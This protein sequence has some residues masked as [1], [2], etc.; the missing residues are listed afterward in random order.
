MYLKSINKT[1]FNSTV[2]IFGGSFDPI[3]QGHVNIANLVTNELNLDELFFM[4]CKNHP[5]KKA[6]KANEDHRLA[7]LELAL[8]DYPHL[9]IDKRE[10]KRSGDSFTFD[11]L[12]SLRLEYSDDS[13]IILLIGS[14]VFSSL[15]SWFR[16]KDI[17]SLTNIVVI[18]RFGYNDLAQIKDEY[19][20]SLLNSAV[21]KIIFPY[22]QIQ[23]L[24]LPH[25]DVSSSDLRLRFKNNN[26]NLSDKYICPIVLDYIVKRKLYA[27]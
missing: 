14:D 7:M 23:I 19:L 9:K 24:S 5:F 11:S 10:L 22:G 12:K 8:N 25:Y 16:Y 4:P 15:N 6:I 18:K 26:F 1:K 17:L 13:K 27:V 3:H 21:N 20:V 2:G